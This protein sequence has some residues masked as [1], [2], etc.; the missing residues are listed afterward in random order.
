MEHLHS[1]SFFNFGFGG[2][3]RKR[4]NGVRVHGGIAARVEESWHSDNAVSDDPARGVMGML[5][6]P[7][8]PPAFHRSFESQKL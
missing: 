6:A 3:V 7:L 4:K 5:S 2:G 8:L 1:V